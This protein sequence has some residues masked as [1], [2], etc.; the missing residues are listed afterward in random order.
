MPLSE[1]E[2]RCV[3]LAS[4][5]LSGNLGGTWIVQ[6]YLDEMYVSGPSHEVVITNGQITAAMEVKRLTGD[7]IYQAYLESLIS[8]QRFLTQSLR[9]LLCSRTA[10]RF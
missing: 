10:Y 7:S 8:N 2:L 6:D 4:G 5:F 9:W 1:Q 3:D